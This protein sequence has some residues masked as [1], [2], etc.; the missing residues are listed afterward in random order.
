[1]GFVF[2]LFFSLFQNVHPASYPMVTGGEGVNQSSQ[3]SHGVNSECSCRATLPA[4]LHA[5][6]RD[7]FNFCHNSFSKTFCALTNIQYVMAELCAET[8]V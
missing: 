5:V 6:E 4:S 1:M 7:N 8:E 2:R 3:F